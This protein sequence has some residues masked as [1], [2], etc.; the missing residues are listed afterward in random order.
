MHYPS[1]GG[2]TLA[3]NLSKIE[4]K[5]S[6]MTVSCLFFRTL[7]PINSIVH[8]IELKF[9]NFLKL[10]ALWTFENSLD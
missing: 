8:L 1:L 3:E 6:E 4:D 5:S 10:F 9:S 7:W 2:N